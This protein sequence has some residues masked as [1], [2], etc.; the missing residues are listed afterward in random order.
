MAEQFHIQDQA[1]SNTFFF[2]KLWNPSRT[3]TLMYGSNHPPGVVGAK[4][5][6]YGL[7][8]MGDLHRLKSASVYALLRMKAMMRSTG[9]RSETS[10]SGW[11]FCSS[12]RS[13]FALATAITRAPAA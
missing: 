10:R 3:A 1:W 13:Y 9:V 6:F 12:A 5:L 7:G 2:Y 11:W 8:V 4:R